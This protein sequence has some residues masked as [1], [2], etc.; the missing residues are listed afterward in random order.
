VSCDGHSHD[1]SMPDGCCMVSSE[2]PGA[3]YVGI[4]VGH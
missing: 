3:Q 1:Y 4:C 2:C